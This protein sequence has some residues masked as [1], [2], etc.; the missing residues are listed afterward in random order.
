MESDPIGLRGRSFSTYGYIGANPLS[1]IDRFGLQEE[2]LPGAEETEEQREENSSENLLRIAEAGSLLSQIRA[3][4][5]RENTGV[6]FYTQLHVDHAV[7][8]TK[9]H[10]VGNVFAKIAGLQN[11]MTFLLFIK[12]GVVDL[13]EGAATEESTA[14]VDFSQGKFE[15]L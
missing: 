5:R 4:D 6:G 14:N 11:P 7:V 9:D 3:L 1:R 12:N 8:K 10:V 15:I 13:L 2:E